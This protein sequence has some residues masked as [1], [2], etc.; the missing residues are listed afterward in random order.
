[1]TY[2]IFS[3]IS[4]ILFFNF[5]TDFQNVFG[6]PEN[7]SSNTLYNNVEL[8]PAGTITLPDIPFL[9]YQD[10]NINF[11]PQHNL[12]DVTIEFSEFDKPI[13]TDKGLI[14]KINISLLNKNDSKSIPLNS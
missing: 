6:Q 1:M 8:P 4:L 14:S 9:L 11:L 12:T 2:K 5:F 3:S 7:P 13:S 10:I